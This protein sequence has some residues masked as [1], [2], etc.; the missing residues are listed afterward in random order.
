L[1]RIIDAKIA[2]REIVAT[3]VKNRMLNQQPTG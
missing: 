2:G 3:E 1:Q